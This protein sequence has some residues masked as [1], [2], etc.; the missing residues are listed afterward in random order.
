MAMS[1][2]KTIYTKESNFGGFNTGGSRLLVLALK[3]YHRITEA[4]VVFQSRKDT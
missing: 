4:E 1:V 2:Q 3:A